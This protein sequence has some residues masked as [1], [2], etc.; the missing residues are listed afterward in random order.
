VWHDLVYRTVMILLGLAGF[1]GWVALTSVASWFPGGDPSYPALPRRSDVIVA[2]VAVAVWNLLAAAL[3]GAGTALLAR[4]ARSVPGLV[5][6]AL[7][8]LISARHAFYIVYGPGTCTT[9]PDGS[10]ETC[11]LELGAWSNDVIVPVLWQLPTMMILLP[12]ATVLGGLAIVA[13]TRGRRQS[14]PLVDR[15]TT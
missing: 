10:H 5:S 12:L 8:A 2:T 4:R 1:V 13:W 9:S 3:V 6:A 14:A 7:M 11:S 15:G